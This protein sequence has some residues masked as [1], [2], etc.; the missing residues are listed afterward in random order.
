MRKFNVD[1]NPK[2]GTKP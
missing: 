2:T 1:L